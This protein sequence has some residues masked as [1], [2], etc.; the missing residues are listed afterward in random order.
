MAQS[1]RLRPRH[2][3]ARGARDR[4]RR[5]RLF[6]QRD[7]PLAG[8]GADDRGRR[9]RGAPLRGLECSASALAPDGPSLDRFGLDGALTVTYT[10]AE[11]V[12]AGIRIRLE[13]PPTDDPDWLVPGVF[14]GENRLEAC[15]RLYPR[16]TPHVDVGRMESN[17][18]SFRADRCGTP[19]VFAGRWAGH[20]G[21]CRWGSRAGQHTPTAAP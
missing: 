4:D 13:L 18:W 21:G 14:Y 6:G 8:R 16:F 2:V 7:R 19:A 11:P 1:H 17:S 9:E 20:H 3:E 5:R 15:T 12:D 10:G